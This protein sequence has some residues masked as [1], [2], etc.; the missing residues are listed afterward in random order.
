MLKISIVTP[1]FNQARYLEECLLSVKEKNYSNL[2]HIV[3]DGAS[4]DGTVGILKQYS[5]LSGW[6]HLRW[7]S[8]P[9]GGQADA[10]NKGLTLATGDILAYLCADDAYAPGAFDFVNDFFRQH[11]EVD[12]IYGECHFIDQ[13]GK[14]VRRKRAPPFHESHLLRRNLILQPTVFF[15]AEVWHRVGLF[16]VSLHYA[17]DYEYWLRA[18]AVCRIVPVERHLAY[19]RLHADSKTV[20]AHRKMLREGYDVACQF[21]G[22]GLLS[23]YLFCVYWPST[24]RLKRWLFSRLVGMR[25]LGWHP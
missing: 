20:K 4:T 12:L 7:I 22:G 1:S 18:S 6:E 19:Y 24:A 21:G 13:R 25:L 2:E 14:V 9:D 3:V 8:E 10:I 17:M 15:R 5:E 23:W 16:S 11:P